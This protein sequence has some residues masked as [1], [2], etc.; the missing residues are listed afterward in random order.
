MDKEDISICDSLQDIMQINKYNCTHLYPHIIQIKNCIRPDIYNFLDKTFP[1]SVNNGQGAKYDDGL[2]G[3]AIYNTL[4]QNEIW[5]QLHQFIYSQKFIDLVMSN[6][7]NE[8]KTTFKDEFLL[9]IDNLVYQESKKL[10]TRNRR[11]CKKKK[12]GIIEK[13][14]LILFLPDLIYLSKGDGKNQKEHRDHE[15]RLFSGLLYFNN[16]KPENRGCTQFWSGPKS[17]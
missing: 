17:K 3:R 1:T 10:Y 9:D 11:Y 2:K 12:R 14:Y 7:R 6:F 8:I 16:F 5:K 4:L 13:K 15:N